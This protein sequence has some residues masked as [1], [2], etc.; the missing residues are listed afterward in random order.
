MDTDTAFTFT[1]FKVIMEYALDQQIEG[2]ARVVK[3]C[4]RCDDV[5]EL[6]PV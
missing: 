4:F 2:Q 3:K 6:N 1:H 5:T